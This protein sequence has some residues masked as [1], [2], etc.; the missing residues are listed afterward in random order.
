MGLVEGLAVVSVAGVV[1]SYLLSGEGKTDISKEEVVTVAEHCYT[2]LYARGKCYVEGETTTGRS[3]VLFSPSQVLYDW[4]PLWPTQETRL[5]RCFPGLLVS[6]WLQFASNLPPSHPNFTDTMLSEA[7]GE[8]L[9]SATRYILTGLIPTLPPLLKQNLTGREQIYRETF[10]CLL[11]TLQPIARKGS[12]MELL[13]KAKSMFPECSYR[14]MLENA[15]KIDP[16]ARFYGYKPTISAIQREIGADLAPFFEFLK[17]L[18]GLL[19]MEARR[20]AV[21][22]RKKEDTKSAHVI[23]TSPPYL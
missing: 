7:S 12:G 1:V 21:E 19:T 17:K 11:K 20:D 4:F 6:R 5:T 14:E 22:L 13:L 3:V 23:K 8:H 15:F 18:D 2:G 16:E 9:I 10:D